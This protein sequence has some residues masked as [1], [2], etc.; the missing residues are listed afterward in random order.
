MER[1]NNSPWGISW[2]H[3]QMNLLKD[4]DIADDICLTDKKW[5]IN[6]IRLI[7][8]GN[9]VGLKVNVTKTKLVRVYAIIHRRRSHRRRRA[10]F[11]YLG[12]LITRDFS[13]CV[14]KIRKHVKPTTCWPGCEIPSISRETWRFF[15]TRGMSV[16]L[17]GW[18]TAAFMQSLQVLINRKKNVSDRMGRSGERLCH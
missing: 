9:H 7:L 10:S 12:S 11:C 16:L 15:R 6:S 5:M 17:C 13:L 2:Q 1:V 3:L 8:Y 14:E 18:K 4:I